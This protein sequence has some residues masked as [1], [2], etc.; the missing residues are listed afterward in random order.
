MGYFLPFYPLPPSND[1][2]NQNFEKKKWKKYLEILSFYTYLSTIKWSSWNIRCDWQKFL[3][4]WT[5]FCIFPPYGL[6][7]SK[8]WKNEKNIWRYYH[9]TNVDHKWQSYDVWFLRYGGRQ[10][11]IFVILGHFLHFYSSNNQKN[12]NL[13]KMKKAPGNIII[14]QMWIINDNHMMYSSWHMELDR[15]NFFVIL[16]SF[17]PFTFLTI[18]KSKLLKKWKKHL[19]ILSFHTSIP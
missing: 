2:E 8:F 19:E 7:K 4:F 14:L 16:D 11:E 12:E 18:Q 1:P 17:F 5:I 10:T 9:F 15:Q 13:K 6:R 3:S